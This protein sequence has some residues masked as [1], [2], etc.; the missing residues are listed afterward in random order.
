[1]CEARERKNTVA[2]GG[3][4]GTSSAWTSKDEFDLR[5]AVFHSGKGAAMTAFAYLEVGNIDSRPLSR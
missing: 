3:A 4:F 1:M 5:L 2:H